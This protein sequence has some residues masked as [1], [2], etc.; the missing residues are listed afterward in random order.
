MSAGPSSSAAGFT[1]LEVLV[2]MS[3]FGVLTSLVYTGMH[4]GVRSWGAVQERSAGAVAERT[5]RNW[6]QRQITA[7]V[8]IQWHERQQTRIAFSGDARGLRFFGVRSHVT[9]GAGL[10][11]VDLRREQQRDGRDALVL[12]YQTRDTERPKALGGV[13]EPVSRRLGEDFESLR[14]DYYGASNPLEQGRWRPNWPSQASRYP[15]MIRISAERHGVR[16]WPSLVVALRAVP[17]EVAP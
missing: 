10:Y 11:R 4:T 17:T 5:M 3:L 6:L 14:F 16:S 9:R 15:E 12:T 7:L 2:A 1:L 8:P 13:G